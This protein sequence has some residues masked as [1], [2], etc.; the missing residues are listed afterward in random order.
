M[1]AVRLASAALALAMVA[2]LR[3]IDAFCASDGWVARSLKNRVNPVE[4]SHGR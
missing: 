2:S 4:V 1:N 3:I